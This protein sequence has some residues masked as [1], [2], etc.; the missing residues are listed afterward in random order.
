MS[1]FVTI[2]INRNS[3]RFLLQLVVQFTL[4]DG[5]TSQLNAFKEGFEQFF[6]TSNLQMFYPHEVSKF[7]NI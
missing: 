1:E 5:V 2:G 4:E 6:K 7:V 3:L